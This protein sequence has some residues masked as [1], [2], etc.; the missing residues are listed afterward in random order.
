MKNRRRGMVAGE[1]VDRRLPLVPPVKISPNSF[2]C[3]TNVWPRRRRLRAV[4]DR[5]AFGGRLR[6]WRTAGRAEGSKES[7]KIACRRSAWSSVYAYTRV[8]KRD[9]VGAGPALSQGVSREPTGYFTTKFQQTESNTWNE[10]EKSAAAAPPAGFPLPAAK[11]R[12]VT[13]RHVSKTVAL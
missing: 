11:T 3:T 4:S 13:V 5:L 10:N 9:S 8:Q 1:E 6:G 2:T 12:E 7:R